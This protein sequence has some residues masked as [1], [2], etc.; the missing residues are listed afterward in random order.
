MA[1]AYTSPEA[2]NAQRR[3][4]GTKLTLAGA[5]LLGAA[6]IGFVLTFLLNIVWLGFIGQA[7]GALAFLAAAIGAACF[8]IGFN[9][10]KEA[11][12]AHRQ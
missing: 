10:I 1:N 6:A 4:D 12:P 7:I 8:V 2:L 5:V 9:K 11:H 3:A